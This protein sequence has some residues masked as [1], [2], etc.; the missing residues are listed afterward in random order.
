MRHPRRAIIASAAV[1]LLVAACGSNDEVAAP[2]P[3]PAPAPQAPAEPED[4]CDYDTSQTLTFTVAFGA[5]GGNDVMSRA[6]GQLLQDYGIW[7]GNVTYE[8]LPG[9]GG[10]LGW[11]T[12]FG[13][14]G[15]PYSISTTSGSFT[16]TPLQADTEWDPTEFTHLALLATDE[17]VMASRGDDARFTTLDD[18]IEFA[19]TQRPIV[20]GVGAVQLDYLTPATVFAAEGLDWSYVA[21][22]D[23]GE[24]IGTLLSG[25]ADVMLRAP[26]SLAGLIEAGEL[27]PLAVT[28]P[29]RLPQLPDVPTF[30]ELGYDIDVRFIRGLVMPPGVDECVV[31]FWADAIAQ[32]VVT[33]EWQT[34]IDA[35]YLTEDLVYGADFSALV[36]DVYSAFE[37]ALR[38]AGVID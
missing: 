37:A 17:V 2:A 13:Q 11:G 27:R 3:A 6:V 7:D 8:N 20:S 15:N 25:S 19:R 33:P 23:T 16:A 22:D 34:Y 30:A 35:N 12:V 29:S 26:G 38:E 9:G 32:L 28:G 31:D 1:A 21:H 5:G 24:A 36:A 18:V 14:T 10:S 4:T